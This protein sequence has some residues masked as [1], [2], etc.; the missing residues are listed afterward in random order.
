MPKAEGFAA[1]LAPKNL[2]TKGPV[3]CMEGF[4]FGRDTRRG[5]IN[6][7]KASGSASKLILVHKVASVALRANHR[8]PN[9]VIEKHS[10]MLSS[11]GSFFRT[12]HLRRQRPPRRQLLVAL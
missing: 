7:P 5:P 6:H 1:P 9:V 10:P 2:D 11:F 8:G 12:E 3:Q 4:K